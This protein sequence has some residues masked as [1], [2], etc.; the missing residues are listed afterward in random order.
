V[1]NTRGPLVAGA[2][3]NP[4]P[5]PDGAF[6]GNTYGWRSEQLGYAADGRGY[7]EVAVHGPAAPPRP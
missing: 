3:E 7:V 1:I 2:P 5:G 6:G 4:A